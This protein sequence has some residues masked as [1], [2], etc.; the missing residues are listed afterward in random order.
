[1]FRDKLK[2]V[3]ARNIICVKSHSDM[4]HAAVG[5]SATLC[6]MMFLQLAAQMVIAQLCVLTCQATLLS[7]NIYIVYNYAKKSKW[8]RNCKNTKKH[9]SHLHLRS[10][11]GDVR[12]KDLMCQLVWP[13]CINWSW[14]SD[15]MVRMMRCDVCVETTNHDGEMNSLVPQE[16]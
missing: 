2:N 9:E 8:Q 5:T 15:K 14:E 4:L 1:M 7:D 3:I 13:I 11:D 6:N 12:R 16:D 10:S